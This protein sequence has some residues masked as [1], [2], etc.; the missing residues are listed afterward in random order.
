MK[1]ADQ[2]G[3][4]WCCVYTHHGE[5]TRAAGSLDA[6]GYDT[7]LP[8]LGTERVKKGQVVRSWEPLFDRYVF[9]HLPLK[10]IWQPARYAPGVAK[11]ISSPSGTPLVIPQNAFEAI[12]TR[13]GQ[14]RAEIIHA[15]AQKERI[16]AKR[17]ERGDS[18]RVLSGPFTGWNGF[19]E[20]SKKARVIVLL[21][22]FGKETRTEVKRNELELVA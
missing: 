5:E 14:E 18:V 7:Y 10:G 13:C 8:R 17:F 12:Y 6:K 11:I 20:L 1:A 16:N 4:A 22:I 3:Y 2:F 15:L 9:V 21:S 19:V